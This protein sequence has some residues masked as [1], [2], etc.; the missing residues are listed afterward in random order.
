MAPQLCH[1]YV[2]GKLRSFSRFLLR[3]SRE[4]SQEGG[5][6]HSL[7]GG[8][9]HS[10]DG[11][12]EHSLDGGREHSLDGG[13]EH[14]LDGGREHSL[15]VVTGCWSSTLQ[16]TSGPDRLSEKYRPARSG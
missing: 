6:E 12:R 5:R 3:F 7:D 14:S 15:P 4:H 1:F 2:P 11:G 8:W 10:L 16:P 9:E 13:R